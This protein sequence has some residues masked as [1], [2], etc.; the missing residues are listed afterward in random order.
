MITHV[1]SPISYLE[2][3][4]FSIS[5]FNIW[6]NIFCLSVT[7]LCLCQRQ[8]PYGGQNGFRFFLT[9]ISAT[10]STVSVVIRLESFLGFLGV[11]RCLCILRDDLETAITSLEIFSSVCFLFNKSPQLWFG[12]ICCSLD[13]LK[14]FAVTLG[15]FA[16]PTLLFLRLLGTS[17]CLVDTIFVCSWGCPSDDSKISGLGLT[18]M[19]SPFLYTSLFWNIWCSEGIF[20]RFS[21]WFIF[22]YGL[23]GKLRLSP[24]SVRFL[25]LFF[26]PQ[27]GE[28]FW[29]GSVRISFNNNPSPRL[30]SSHLFFSIALS[31]L[32]IFTYSGLESM[33]SFRI[34]SSVYLGL[35]GL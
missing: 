34:L 33:L 7:F 8:H 20:Q 18:K 5:S 3:W 2:A 16:T 30:F 24:G 21:F 17:L 35:L 12:Q 10:L 13:G 22:L 32:S 27:K 9:I 4:T 19:I 23:S 6:L 11:F 25:H 14:C 15:S 29:R 28:R 26:L 31:S 1:R